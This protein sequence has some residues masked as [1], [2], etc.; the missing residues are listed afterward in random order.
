MPGCQGGRS[1]AATA[2]SA[3]RRQRVGP[4]GWQAARADSTRTPPR[5]WGFGRR[6][7]GVPKSLEGPWVGGCRRY[8][9]GRLQGYAVHRHAA[10]KGFAVTFRQPSAGNVRASGAASTLQRSRGIP[11]TRHPSRCTFGGARPTLRARAQ[12][13]TKK[14]IRITSSAG[15]WFVSVAA[16][17]HR[18]DYL[19]QQRPRL[20]S[21]SASRRRRPIFSLAPCWVAPRPRERI[22]ILDQ[23]QAHPKR[24]KNVPRNPPEA[25]DRVRAEDL[26][27]IPVRQAGDVVNNAVRNVELGAPLA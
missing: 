18:H 21:C 17:S 1:P 8:A 11:H 16:Y 20:P 12:A 19:V 10:S 5:A 27:R 7:S 22:C 2:D 9:R 6:L 15:G 13:P 3:Q 4:V 24:F 14:A 25:L 23:N 26:R